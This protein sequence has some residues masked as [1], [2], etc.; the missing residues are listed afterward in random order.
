ML[1]YGNKSFNVGPKQNEEV[2]LIL[3]WLSLSRP[4]FD[5]LMWNHRNRKILFKVWVDY[6]DLLLNQLNQ[7]LEFSMV[8]YLDATLNV[9]L[10]KKSSRFSF[11]IENK[12]FPLFSQRLTLIFFSYN[13]F[14]IDYYSETY[15][16]KMF[17]FRY[18]FENILNSPQQSNILAKFSASIANNTYQR[19]TSSKNKIL[20]ICQS[21]DNPRH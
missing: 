7:V 19:Q 9:D 18:L 2:P 20:E 8:R 21:P 16:K 1:E 15:L 12:S 4:F 14:T 6:F 5:Q 13:D 11:C 3:S 17:K 10:K